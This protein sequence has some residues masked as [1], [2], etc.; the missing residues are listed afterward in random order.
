MDGVVF[1]KMIVWYNRR[2][3]GAILGHHTIFSRLL[4]A[5]TA[6]TLGLGRFF[7]ARNKYRWLTLCRCPRNWADCWLLAR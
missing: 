7:H 5:A 4:F 1:L 3:V 2:S 6:L